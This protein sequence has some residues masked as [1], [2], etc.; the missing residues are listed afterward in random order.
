MNTPAKALIAMSGGI[1]S[2]IAAYMMKKTGYDCLGMTMKLMGDCSGS[3]EK[4]KVAGEYYRFIS[5]DEYTE[6]ASASARIASRIGIPFKAIDFSGAFRKHVM[7]RFVSAY[8]DGRTPN[9][10]VDCNKHIKFGMLLDLALEMGF[11]FL[12]TGHYARITRDEESGLYRL[13]KALDK[14]RDQ[15]YFLFNLTQS[16]L[17]HIMFPLGDYH[18]SDIRKLASELSLEN[19]ERKESRD[20]CFVP[21]GD[22]GVFLES[23]TGHEYAG[24]EFIT[25]DGK[26]PGHHKGAVR[27]TIGQRKGLGLSVP[28]PVYVLGKDMASNRV[29]VGEE[30]LLFGKEMTISD[31][32]WTSVRPLSEPFRCRI[33]I[34]FRQSPASALC[35]PNGSGTIKVFFDEPQRAITPGQAAVMYDGDIV[36]GGGVIV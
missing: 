19:T 35:Q 36:I 10:C 7:R 20:I 9:P 29:F 18:K 31:V 4:F 22:Y 13:R 17:S 25:A 3:D 1:D 21:D 26:C 30:A 34:R 8:E 33:K 15:S 16:R 27:Y 11:D 12:V 24:G 23:F 2:S 32:N 28:S 14:T 6:E 5:P